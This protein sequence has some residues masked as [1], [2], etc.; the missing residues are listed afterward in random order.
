ML[1]EFLYRKL[2]GS[3]ETRREPCSWPS[4]S[5]PILKDHAKRGGNHVFSQVSLP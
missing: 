4:F 5:T 3:R 2:K 1:F